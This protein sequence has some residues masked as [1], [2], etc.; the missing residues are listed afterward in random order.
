MKMVDTLVCAEVVVYWTKRMN[1]Y[2]CVERIPL[3]ELGVGHLVEEIEMEV[4]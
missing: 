2:D 1:S 3:A 4:Q